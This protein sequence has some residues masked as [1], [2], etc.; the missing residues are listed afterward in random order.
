MHL[1]NVARRYALSPELRDI[2]RVGNMKNWRNRNDC[3]ATKYYT[4][5]LLLQQQFIYEDI[6]RV[7]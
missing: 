3:T 2:A 1:V 6:Y 7:Q 5:V 4:G